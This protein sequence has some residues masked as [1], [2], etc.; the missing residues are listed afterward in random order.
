MVDL[1]RSLK[2]RFYGIMNAIMLGIDNGK[3]PN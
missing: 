2:K 1:A 3:I